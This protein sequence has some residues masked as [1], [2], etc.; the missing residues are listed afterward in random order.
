MELYHWQPNVKNDYATTT[1]W[2]AFEGGTDNGQTTP[3]TVR[4]AVAQRWTGPDD[5]PASK[6]KEKE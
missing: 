6:T 3:E 4:E 2:Y 5:M 1:H